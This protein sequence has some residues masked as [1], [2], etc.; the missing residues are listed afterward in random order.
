MAGKKRE[1]QL[2]VSMTYQQCLLRA[3]VLEDPLTVVSFLQA[4][5]NSQSLWDEML[6]NKGLTGTGVLLV[7]QP[8][9]VRPRAPH[10]P[11]GRS[12]P[13]HYQCK[14]LL[15]ALAPGLG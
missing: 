15:C 8:L 2:Q 9:G 5:V 14:N 3:L 1:I 4:V 10:G 7:V 12:A 6:Q 11:P 13:P